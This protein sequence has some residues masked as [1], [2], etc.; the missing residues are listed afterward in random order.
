MKSAFAHFDDRC[1]IIFERIKLG[2][3]E[4]RREHSLPGRQR[5]GEP[6]ESSEG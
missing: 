1:R 4:L 5:R 2:F 3:R 6:R